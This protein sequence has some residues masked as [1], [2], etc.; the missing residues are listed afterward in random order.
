MPQVEGIVRTVHQLVGT[1]QAGGVDLVSLANNHTGDFGLEGLRETL[2]VLDA[3]GIS[4]AGAGVDRRSAREPALLAAGGAR[5]SVVACADYPAEW[6]AT[7]TSPGINYVPV[8]LD[9]SH[10]QEVAAAVATARE[11]ADLVVFSIH[12]GPN[13][14]ARPTPEFRSFARAVIDAGAD[15]FWGHSAHVVQ[16]AE[17]RR[18]RLILYDTGDLVDDYAVDGHLRNDLSALFLVRARPPL[19]EDVEVVPV[20]IDDLR[21]SLARDPDRAWFVERFRRHCAELGMGVAADART[22]RLAIPS[23]S[24]PPAGG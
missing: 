15:I 11:Q 8:S 2:A 22:V 19:V 10:F 6:A 21:V 1:L 4:H 23:A 24:D 20:R 9:P 14:R 13:M 12:W 5:V 17:L 18:G 16:G 3:A 7:P